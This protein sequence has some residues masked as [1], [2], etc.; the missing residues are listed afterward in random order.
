QEQEVEAGGCVGE[1]KWVVQAEDEMGKQYPGVKT[2]QPI[3]QFN[4]CACI[5]EAIVLEIV[6][7]IS[8]H[9]KESPGQKNGYEAGI[10]NFVLSGVRSQSRQVLH[11][12]LLIF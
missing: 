4:H 2:G 6:S 3:E 8:Q 7:A 11:S 12:A 9:T 10:G 1:G 5:A